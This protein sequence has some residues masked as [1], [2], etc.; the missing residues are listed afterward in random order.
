MQ[1]ARRGSQQRFGF[2]DCIGAGFSG[3]AIHTSFEGIVGLLG[4][5]AAPRG[6]F[7]LLADQ[8]SLRGLSNEDISTL[9][10]AEQVLQV[11]GITNASTIVHV[12]LIVQANSIDLLHK[13]FA[14][15]RGRQGSVLLAAEVVNGSDVIA[16][17]LLFDGEILV[18]LVGSEVLIA[19]LQ[20][21]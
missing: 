6:S 20:S 13:G 2:C 21:P 19:T 10:R 4:G 16:T 5:Q 17:S 7:L 15:E 1:A 12:Q 14:V 18:V 9:D 3:G 8:L 11:I